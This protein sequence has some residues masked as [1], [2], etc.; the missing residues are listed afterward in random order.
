MMD[1]LEEHCSQSGIQEVVELV[2][3][4]PNGDAALPYSYAADYHHFGLL[5]HNNN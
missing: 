2:V 1:L 3:N 4:E 5:Y